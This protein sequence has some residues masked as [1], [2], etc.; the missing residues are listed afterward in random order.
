MVAAKV[1]REIAP[2][3]YEPY[4]EMPAEYREAVIQ[5]LK[6]QARIESEY[7]MMPEKTLVPAMKL[8]PNPD[9]WVRYASFWAQEVEHASYWNKMLAELG[10]TIDDEF[11]STPKPIYIFD[12]RD[13]EGKHWVDWVRVQT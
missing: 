4:D 5:V 1:E 11:M 2:F 7:P 9:E 6:I 3:T 8:A 13:D 10:I 12:M